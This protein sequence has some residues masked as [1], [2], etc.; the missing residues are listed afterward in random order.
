MNIGERGALIASPVLPPE[1]TAVKLRFFLCPISSD[2]PKAIEFF[3][4]ATVIRVESE[5]VG[6]AGSG[7]AVEA[8][9]AKMTWPSDPQ[10]FLNP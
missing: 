1:G 3:M 2:H 4:R 8:Q 7:F 9:A 5:D 6:S 10:S